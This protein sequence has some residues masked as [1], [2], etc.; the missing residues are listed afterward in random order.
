MS[1]H[2]NLKMQHADLSSRDKKPFRLSKK[3]AR[4]RIGVS[5]AI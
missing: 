2:R 5:C 4:L 1:K 3:F